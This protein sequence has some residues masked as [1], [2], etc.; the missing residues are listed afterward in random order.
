MIR[1]N[2]IL[3]ATVLTAQV[4]FSTDSPSKESPPVIEEY[5]IDKEDSKMRFEVAHLVISTVE[6][7]FKNF[8]GSF[9]FAPDRLNADIAKNLTLDVKVD[10]ASID[11][12]IEKRDN[13]LRSP[14]FFNA[15]EFPFMTFKG[16]SVKITG[17]KAFD[18]TGD[19]TIKGTTKAVTLKVEYLGKVVAYDRQKVVFKAEAEINRQ[20]FGLKWNDFIEIGP[21]VG[22]N[23]TIKLRVGGV[24]KKDL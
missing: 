6:G 2:L 4:S 15:K 12:D 14:D 19:L 16:K 10:V 17:E 13:H 21:A 18:L 9:T 20:D 3:A 24:R 22:D 8:E 5:V 23:I 1:T 11:T 7:F